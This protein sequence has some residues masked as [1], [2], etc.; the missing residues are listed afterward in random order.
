M[1]IGELCKP[2]GRTISLIA[3]YE[4]YYNLRLLNRFSEQFGDLILLKPDVCMEDAWVRFL[5]ALQL[6]GSD[7]RTFLSDVR[8]DSIEKIR[9]EFFSS[10][11][12]P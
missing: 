4:E 11:R 1:T 2:S 7:E 12:N 3:A 5:V 9:T 8:F 6:L 10:I